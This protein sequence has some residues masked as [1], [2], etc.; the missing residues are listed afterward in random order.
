MTE[1]V[2]DLLLRGKTP[3]VFFREQR[4]V[5]DADHEDAAASA[6][7]LTVEAEGGFDGSR[8]TGGSGEVVSNSAVVDSNGHVSP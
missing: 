5:A 2:D 6:D 3:F 7:E 4:L 8:Q 1:L